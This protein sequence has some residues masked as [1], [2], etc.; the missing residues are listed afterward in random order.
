M[1]D[2]D[3]LAILREGVTTWN[4]W[5]RAN[6]DVTEPKLYAANLRQADLRNADLSGAD[7]LQANLFGADLGEANL[8]RAR[9][10]GANVHAHTLETLSSTARHFIGRT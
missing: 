9:L 1:E 3:H 2:S 4:E 8:S 7:L 6:R 5:R 10:T